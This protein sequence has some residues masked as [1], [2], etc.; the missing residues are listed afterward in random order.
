MSQVQTFFEDT[1]NA[2]AKYDLENLETIGQ[3]ANDFNIDPPDTSQLSKSLADI[4]AG[5]PPLIV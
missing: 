2:M 1:D 3:I 4:S 5:G